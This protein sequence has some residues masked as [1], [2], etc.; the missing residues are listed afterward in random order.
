MTSIRSTTGVRTAARRRHMISGLL[1]VVLTV[2]VL[3]PFGLMLIIA[4]TPETSS[5]E[6]LTLDNFVYALTQ[7]NLLRSLANSSI[8]AVVC[9]ASNCVLAILAG[10]SFALL[11]F[12]GSQALF[13]AIVATTAVPVSVTLIP[14]FLMVRAVPLAGGNDILGQGGSGLLNTLV[15]IA[16]P[17]LIGAMNVFLARQFFLSASAELGEAAR[18]DGAREFTIFL[19]IYLPLAKPLVAVVAILTFVGVWDEFLWALVITQSPEIETVQLSLAKFA[20]SGNI[21]FG[22]LMAASLLVTLPVI[23]VFLFYQ[24]GFIA[25]LTEGSV[26]G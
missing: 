18:I 8:V 10:Y 9:V 23:L 11:P 2:I 14:L 25:G 15:G 22:P 4:L 12:R 6:S 5:G 1:L 17:S 13:Y 24:R 3:L 7:G 26:K 19:R 20:S 16:I 21:Q